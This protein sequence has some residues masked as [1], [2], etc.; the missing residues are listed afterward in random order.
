M[1]ALS[2]ETLRNA[3]RTSIYGRRLGLD[4]IADQAGPPVGAGASALRG[5]FLVGVYGMRLPVQTPTTTTPTTLVPAGYIELGATTASTNTFAAPIPGAE[6]TITQTATSTLGHQIK[7]TAGNFNSSTGS[8]A[9]SC[10]FWGQGA[11]AR[12]VGLST[13]ILACIAGLGQTTAA[14]SFST[15]A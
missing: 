5:G 13:G 4:N 3:I 1:S 10:F 7:L 12:F 2:L 11:T 14:I 6:V 8:S 9:I 15:A